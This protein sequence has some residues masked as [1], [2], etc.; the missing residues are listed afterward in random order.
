VRKMATTYDFKPPIG[1]K[2]KLPAPKRE[3]V[4]VIPFRANGAQT[5][6]LSAFLV[7]E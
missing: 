7:L 3:I 4:H 2:R 1:L 6:A 5:W